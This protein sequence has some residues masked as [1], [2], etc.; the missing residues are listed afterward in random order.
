[1]RHK[2]ISG[3]S[4]TPRNYRNTRTFRER[5]GFTTLKEHGSIAVAPTQKVKFSITGISHP[6]P[7]EGEQTLR[8]N[9]LYTGAIISLVKPHNRRILAEGKISGVFTNPNTVSLDFGFSDNWIFFY[10][11]ALNATFPESSAGDTR[12]YCEKK[13]VVSFIKDGREALSKS[14]QALNNLD[15]I[16]ETNFLDHDMVNTIATLGLAYKALFHLDGKVKLVV[17]LFHRKQLKI[18]LENLDVLYQK[19]VTFLNT[20]NQACK[21]RGLAPIDFT[22]IK[23]PSPL[24]S[25][26][27]IQ[28][29][30][31]NPSLFTH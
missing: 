21:T 22:P 19:T 24:N 16:N 30:Q 20:M 6:A 2:I 5:V 18:L 4:I 11:K 27:L 13:Q 3:V 29:I 7:I 31:E 26:D 1:M 12:C 14:Q 25:T 8:W 23:K 28:W 17:G 9:S 15:K 10:A